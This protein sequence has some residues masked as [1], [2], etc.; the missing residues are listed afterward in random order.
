MATVQTDL[1]IYG[2]FEIPYDAPKKGTSKR[3]SREHAKQFWASADLGDVKGKQGCYVFA[4][5]ASGG[6]MPWYVGKATKTFA[7][8]ALHLKTAVL[9][10]VFDAL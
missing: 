4:L 8:E 7:Q 1:V 10:F 3:I 9:G 2:P 5:A 6:Y